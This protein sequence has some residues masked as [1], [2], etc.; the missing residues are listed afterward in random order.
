MKLIA[1]FFKLVRWPNLVIIGVT[2]LLFY[3]S[4]VEPL[5]HKGISTHF[6]SIHFLLLIIASVLIAAAGYI[7]ND[8]FDLNID[9]VNKPAKLVIDKDIKRRWAIVQHILFSLAGIFISFYIDLTSKTF[10]LGFSNFVCVFL[11]FGYSITLK[12]KLLIG[13][14]L[15]SALT[16]WVIIV[17]FLCY[18]NSFYCVSCDHSFLDTYNRRFIRIYCF[19][20]VLLLPFH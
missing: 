7:I 17:A 12:R 4:L 8:Y 19:M 1:A 2:Q 3:Y 9:Q 13:N 16:A 6:N 11:L 5:Y 10:W 15:I 14:V 20:Q 18:Y